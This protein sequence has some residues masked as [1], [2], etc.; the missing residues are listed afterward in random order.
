MIARKP[1]EYG[2]EITN[3]D[4]LK[5]SD[6]F[7]SIVK[8]ISL[9]LNAATI[10]DVCFRIEPPEDNM[11][12]IKLRCTRASWHI[13][14]EPVV[15]DKFFNG[16][17]GIRAQYY[18]SPYQGRLMNRLLLNTLHDRLVDLA[19]ASDPTVDL[20]LVRSSLAGESAKAWISEKGLN[21]KKI[22]RTSDLSLTEEELKND[23]LDIARQVK[24]GSICNENYQLYCAAINGVRAP[25]PDQLEIKGAWLTQPDLVEYV[26][27]DKRDRDCQLFMFGFT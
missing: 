15:L 11:A 5:H 3:R 8:E 2:N 20:S 6:S 10:S 1:W 7:E 19:V 23:W 13:P 18:A 25:I 4:Y 27:T 17:M 12:L 24:S 22:I 26:T 21:G 16:I 9:T 14:V